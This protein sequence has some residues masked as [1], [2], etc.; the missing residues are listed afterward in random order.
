V[1]WVLSQSQACSGAQAA[2]AAAQPLLVWDL[3]SPP[4]RGSVSTFGHSR[5]H[6]RPLL[7]SEGGRV[8]H[9]D[10]MNTK[11]AKEKQP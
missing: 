2:A 10:P 3:R 1:A 11:P 5:G 9:T 7:A 6:V 4:R 8:Q